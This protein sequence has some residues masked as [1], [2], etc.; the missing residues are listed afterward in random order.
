MK[1]AK[2]TVIMH[3]PLGSSNVQGNI[4]GVGPILEAASSSVDQEQQRQRQQ[5][6]FHISSYGYLD[7]Q[8]NIV[9]MG[10]PLRRNKL[11]RMLAGF[12]KEDEPGTPAPQTR[13]N[14][15]ARISSNDIKLAIETIPEE[16]R[17]A[18]KKTNILIAEDNPVAQKLLCKQLKRYGFNITCANNGAE[19]IA[20]WTKRPVGYF[21][22]ALFDHHMPKCDGVE[23]TKTIRRYEKEQNS[24]KRLPIVALTADIQ[25]SARAICVDAGMDG[26]LTKPLNEFALLEFVKQYCID[27]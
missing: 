7:E 10:V 24:K 15:F 27:R 9:R 12:L 8:Q 16:H 2:V 23:A 1:R 17:K 3:Y 26:Y 4:G 21:K 6:P 18:F 20:A 5:Q 25:D 19:A 13:P 11:L 14:I 22:M